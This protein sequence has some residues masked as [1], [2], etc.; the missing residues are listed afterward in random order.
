MGCIYNILFRMMYYTNSKFRN[1][2]NNIHKSSHIII[3][4]DSDDE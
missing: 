1:A 3:N 2:A 4:D